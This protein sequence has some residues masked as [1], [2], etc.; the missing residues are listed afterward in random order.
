MEIINQ[1]TTGTIP[2]VK[3]PTLDLSQLKLAPTVQVEHKTLGL[4]V[5]EKKYEG[6]KNVFVANSGQKD[7][8]GDQVVASGMDLKR[9][10]ANGVVFYQHSG[11]YSND[12]DDV[13][14]RGN[15]WVEGE[16][17]MLGISEWDTSELAKEVKRKVDKGFIN[18]ASIGFVPQKQRYL[19]DKKTLLI[20]K[21]ELLEVSVVNI[22]AD[23]KAVKVKSMRSVDPGDNDLSP[24]EIQKKKIN[25]SIY[26]RKEYEKFS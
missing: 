16:A 12:P 1:T 14:A 10:N 17:L 11:Y 7:S 8:V 9:Y 24:E 18:G 4:A 13:I 2:P 25:V 20:E 23:P 5:S 21:A 6:Y 19:E 22:P 15:V 26:L 3:L